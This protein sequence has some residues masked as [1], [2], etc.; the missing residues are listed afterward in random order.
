ME[1]KTFTND[2]TTHYNVTI[3]RSSIHDHANSHCFMKMLQGSLKE[4]Q[5]HWPDNNDKNTPLKQKFSTTHNTD[6]VTYINGK[7]LLIIFQ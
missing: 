2:K 3:S 7:H 6:E 5:Y 4:T 1:G